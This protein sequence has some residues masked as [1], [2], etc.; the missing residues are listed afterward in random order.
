MIEN[1]TSSNELEKHLL[2]RPR[3][4]GQTIACGIIYGSCAVYL[5]T[6]AD[7]E[8]ESNRERERERG[9][10]REAS[11]R[12][13]QPVAMQATHRWTLFFRGP[14]D[15]DLSSFVSQVAFS[16]H[17][18]FD[19]PVRVITK[20]PFECTEFG[21]GEFEAMIRIFF[22]DPTESPV[23]IH[24]VLRLY[25]KE[26][27]VNNVKK[28]VVSAFYDEIVFTNPST[29]FRRLL[30]LY[31]A[32]ATKSNNPLNEHLT[33]IDDSADLQRIYEAQDHVTREI[34]MTKQAL[35]QFEEK[36]ITGNSNPKPKKSR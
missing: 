34:N 6:A 25:H 31:A 29:Q 2:K 14:N 27:P 10:T 28:P 35:L 11:R 5:G 22:R 33:Q 4:D 12:T 13:I 20:P 36:N 24:H 9:G 17:P 21:W 1:D 7:R 15:E 16:L 23:D 30:L 18:S 32:P 19:E 8:R 26:G 3:I